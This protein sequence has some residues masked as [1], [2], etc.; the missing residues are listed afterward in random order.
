[1]HLLIFR[2]IKKAID[3]GMML[4][5]SL[6]K[7]LATKFPKVQKIMDWFGRE[8]TSNAVKCS[9][10]EVVRDCFKTEIVQ[11]VQGTKIGN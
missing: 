6:G 3:Y 8:Q 2:W 10:K 1:M 7:Y 9:P 11:E 4:L 5:G